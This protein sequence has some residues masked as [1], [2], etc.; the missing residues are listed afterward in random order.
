MCGLVGIIS[1]K[2]HGFNRGDFDVFQDMLYMDAL[3][4]W[5]STGCFAINQK[6][7]VNWLKEASSA[8]EFITTKGFEE[9]RRRN[10]YSARCLIGHNR[11]ATKG[12]IIDENAHPFVEGHHILVHNGILIN[13]KKIADTE[14][15]SHA[16]A[17][18][19]LEKGVIEAI[20]EIDG[21]FAIIDYDVEKK[22]LYAVR[23]KERPLVLIE[24]EEL[25]ILCSEG[26]MGYAAAMRN[27]CKGLKWKEVALNTSLVFDM[28]DSKVTLSEETVEYFT[29]K[30]SEAPSVFLPPTKTEMTGGASGKK[31]YESKHTNP[32]RK[33]RKEIAT[34]LRRKD[35]ELIKDNNLNLVSVEDMKKRG[36]DIGNIIAWVPE[37]IDGFKMFGTY[38]HDENVSITWTFPSHKT[39]AEYINEAYLVGR[40]RNCLIDTATNH[41][42]ALV[43]EVRI[44][45]IKYDAAGQFITD[46][47]FMWYNGKCCHC[48]QDVT[49]DD[50]S[51]SVIDVKQT[52]TMEVLCPVCVGHPQ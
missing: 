25:Y 11:K 8:G 30:K 2:Q 22:K 13:H 47:M 45:T 50:L 12:A 14:V 27:G 41:L 46:D 17:H 9:F 1:K 35:T 34:M 33:E 15:D 21:A 19:F 10:E 29:E 5:D 40:I 16:L 20:P 48:K 51:N 39:S 24:T 38:A 28:T 6:G 32:T 44:G 3:R 49:F 42:I 26:A 52:G 37:R 18:L 7:N 31:H 36:L 4:G 43:D 23:N